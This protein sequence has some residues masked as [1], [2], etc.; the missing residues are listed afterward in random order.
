MIGTATEFEWPCGSSSAPT[1]SADSTPASVS[2]P[3]EE[4]VEYGGCSEVVR[5]AAGLACLYEAGGS[6]RL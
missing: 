2:T 6:L 5:D 3:V 4:A 1:T